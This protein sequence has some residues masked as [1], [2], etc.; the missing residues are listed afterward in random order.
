MEMDG[1]GLELVYGQQTGNAGRIANVHYSDLEESSYSAL[2]TYANFSLDYRKNE[3]GDSGLAK[4]GQAGDNEG[5]SIC[6]TYGMGNISVGACQVETSAVDANN[7]SNSSQTRTYS[8]EY[9][10]G[11]GVSLGVVYFDVEQT[12]NSVVR[13]DVDGIATKL[14][15]GF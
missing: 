10:L 1:I 14:S 13:T 3:S 4:D 15:I 7:R 12:A 9:A 6:G 5:T 11:G 8:A 2:I